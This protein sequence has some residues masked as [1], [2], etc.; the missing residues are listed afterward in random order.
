MKRQSNLKVAVC[1]LLSLA[2]V[3]CSAADLESDLDLWV[4]GGKWPR[5]DRAEESTPSRQYARAKQFELVGDA[6]QAAIAWERLAFSYPESDEAEEAL[7]FSAKNHL[8]A[9]S[10]T[11]C[12]AMIEELRR[13]YANP[14]YLDAMGQVE[15]E[16]GRGYLEGKGEGGTFALASRVRKARRIFQHILDEDSEGR[17]ADDALLGLGQCDEADGRF[18][19]A[20]EKYKKLLDKYPR[21]ELRAETEGRIA[22]CINRREPRPQYTESDTMEALNRIQAAYKEAEFGP[23]NLDKVALQEN[24]RVLRDRQAEKRFEQ[25]QFYQT[26]RRFRAAEVYYELIVKRYPDSPW[27]AKASEELQKMRQ[28]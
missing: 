23:T 17:W 3:S 25:A 28:R 2:A 27:S 1:G 18:D 20:I 14:T 13:R 6:R 10:F 19:T 8:A 7:I 24:E 16:L 11:K 21:S 9:G 5:S 4:S 26:N 15:A 12:R 22:I